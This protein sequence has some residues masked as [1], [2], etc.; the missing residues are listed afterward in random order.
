MSLTYNGSGRAHAAMGQADT[1][2]SLSGEIRQL[3]PTAAP[4]RADNASI[5]P[6]HHIGPLSSTI[7]RKRESTILWTHG[8]CPGQS[9]QPLPQ[10]KRNLPKVSKFS[11]SMLF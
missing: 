10:E 2:V 9:W 3:M 7:T 6:L 4:N 1:N 8:E 11:Q 5:I